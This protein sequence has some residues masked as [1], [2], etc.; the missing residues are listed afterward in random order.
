MTSSLL[1]QVKA[2]YKA[3]PVAPNIIDII[4]CVSN[5][6]SLKDERKAG[7]SKFFIDRYSILLTF[8]SRVSLVVKNKKISI[9]WEFFFHVNS[10]R[11]KFYCFDPQRGGLVTW[12]QKKVEKQNHLE[13]VSP[14]IRRDH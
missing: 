7:S 8:G 3:F 13:R 4:E 10:S 9:F 12:L 14:Y 2:R 11:K 1:H 6:M 5:G